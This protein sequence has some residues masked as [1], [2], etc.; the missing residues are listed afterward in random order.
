MSL[1]VLENAARQEAGYMDCVG[2]L[3]EQHIK[4][5][6]NLFSALLKLSPSEGKIPSGTARGLL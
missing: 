2:M 5:L 6:L 3:L 1:H 4:V